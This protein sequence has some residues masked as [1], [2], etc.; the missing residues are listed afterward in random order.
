MNDILDETLKIFQPTDKLLFLDVGWRIVLLPCWFVWTSIPSSVI[1]FGI[2]VA[3][4]FIT[5]AA[6]GSTWGWSLMGSIVCE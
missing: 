2:I 6:I 1:A 5:S 3:W 4:C